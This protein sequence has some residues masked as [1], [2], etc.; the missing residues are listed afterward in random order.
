MR[1]SHGLPEPS[2]SFR[3]VLT[4]VETSAMSNP[5]RTI[6]DLLQPAMHPILRILPLLIIP[7]AGAP[8]LGQPKAEQPVASDEVKHWIDQLSSEIYAVRESATEQLVSECSV[9]SLPQLEAAV[10]KTT[11][12]ETTIR[13]KGLIAKIKDERMQSCI[14]KF[15]RS[16]DDNETFGLDGWKT[17]SKAGGPSRSS[18]KLFLMLYD[19]Y[20]DLVNRPIESK[21]EA[22]AMARRIAA[23]LQERRSLLVSS[24]KADGL[25]LLYCLNA[26]EELTDVHIERLCVDTFRISPFG[27]FIMEPLLRKPLERMLSNWSLTLKNEQFLCM[28]L[29]LEKDIPACRDLG[30][31]IL[32][33]GKVEGEAFPYL[34]AMQAIFRYG[35][36]EDLPQ[37]ERWLN[38]KTICTLSERFAFPAN[39]DPNG[40]GIVEHSVEMRDVALLTAMR[41]NGEDLQLVF[42]MLQAHPLRGFFDESIALPVS[43]DKLRTERVE[44][45]KKKRPKAK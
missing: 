21:E 22:L 5:K 25:A 29:F 28:L 17:F 15:L 26:A 33:S 42:P 3:N 41:L 40:K 20:P 4:N 30:L 23:M 2:L 10:A 14:Q 38:D 19:L 16:K 6:R 45:W 27:P 36:K 32:E 9:D 13:L 18:K 8:A 11:D 35:T 37:V 43:D 24:E 44:T 39:Q 12:F 34:L 31:K 1:R 7:M